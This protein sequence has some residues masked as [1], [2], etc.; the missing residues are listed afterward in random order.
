MRSCT[1]YTMLSALEI[2][3]LSFER[4]ID[5]VDNVLICKE[6]GVLKDERAEITPQ[7]YI[8]THNN[9][10]SKKRTNKKQK[11]R[12]NKNAYSLPGH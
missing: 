11:K 7:Q 1:L 6:K 8:T 5:G 10:R 4:L 12:F 2:L 9:N 3:V